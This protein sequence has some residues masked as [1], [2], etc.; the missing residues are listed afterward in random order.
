MYQLRKVRR[1]C[2]DEGVDLHLPL[3]RLQYHRLQFCANGVKGWQV[4]TG[5]G[6]NSPL[7]QHKLNVKT[8]SP[9]NYFQLT[10]ILKLLV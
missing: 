8:K 6:V 1:D 4:T 10:G 7:Q 5:N 3:F 2:R 9:G